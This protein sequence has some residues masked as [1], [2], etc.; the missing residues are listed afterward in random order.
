MSVQFLAANI[1][2]NFDGEK[3][4]IV[5]QSILFVIA[6]VQNFVLPNKLL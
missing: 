5:L 1:Y 4:D 2:K 6:G 3:Q